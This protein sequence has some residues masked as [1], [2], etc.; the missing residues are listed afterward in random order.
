MSPL[1][2]QRLFDSSKPDEEIWTGGLV[3][4]S[5]VNISDMPGTVITGRYQ[6][7]VPQI[8]AKK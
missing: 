5:R 3:T 7:D 1:W 2:N 4:Q 6:S 8:R